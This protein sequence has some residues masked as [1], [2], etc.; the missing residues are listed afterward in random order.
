M[1]PVNRSGPQRSAKG[2]TAMTFGEIAGLF[3]ITWAVV[4]FYTIVG[5]P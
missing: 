4:S 1:V 2:A 3:I 5:G